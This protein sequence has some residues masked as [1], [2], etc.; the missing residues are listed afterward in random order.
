VPQRST[1]EALSRVL[2]GERFTAVH[3]AKDNVLALILL[4]KRHRVV[5]HD[6][7]FNLWLALTSNDPLRT[8][9]AALLHDTLDRVVYE[10]PQ[11]IIKVKKKRSM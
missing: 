11:G 4:G 6:Q 3:K 7:F 2:L 1:H 5:G 9:A 10:T 8:Y